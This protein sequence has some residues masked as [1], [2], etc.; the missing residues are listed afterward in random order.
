[1][2]VCHSLQQ[3][4]HVRLDLSLKKMEVQACAKSEGVYD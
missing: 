4:D 2:Q 1:M 3:L